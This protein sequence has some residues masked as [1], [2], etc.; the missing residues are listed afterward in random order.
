M[1]MTADCVKKY[2]LRIDGKTGAIIGE[3]SQD[4]RADIALDKLV[5][6]YAVDHNVT[7]DAAFKQVVIDPQHRDLVVAYAGVGDGE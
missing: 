1:E 4:E 5:R 6:R 3:Y 7:Y 2:A